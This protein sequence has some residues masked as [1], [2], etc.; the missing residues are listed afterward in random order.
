MTVFFEEPFWVCIY[1]RR[2]SGEMQVCRIVFGKEPKDYEVYAF[3]LGNYHTLKFGPAVK[4]EKKDQP[5][6]INPKRMQRRARKQVE[7]AGMGTKA[8]QAVSLAREEN[9]ILRTQKRRLKKQEEKERQYS[10]RQKKKKNKHR[11]R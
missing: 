5:C 2:F 11:G 4:D 10:L 9:K 8:Q 7:S 3:L 1:E 6:R